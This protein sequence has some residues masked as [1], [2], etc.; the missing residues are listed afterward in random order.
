MSVEAPD[1]AHEDQ[2]AHSQ[3]LR[4]V[5]E[6]GVVDTEALDI[7]DDMRDELGA[8]RKI[9]LGHTALETGHLVQLPDGVVVD[10]DTV[11]R[12]QE[13]GQNFDVPGIR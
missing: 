1:T 6:N 11:R 7:L 5:N 3:L 13:A 4:E 2:L 8:A 12:D 10:S 9:D